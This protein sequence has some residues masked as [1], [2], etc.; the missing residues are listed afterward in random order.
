MQVREMNSGMT[1]RQGEGYLETFPEYGEDC[2]HGPYVGYDFGDGWVMFT[3][4]N[5]PG[6]VSFHYEGEEE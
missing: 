5:K 6:L 1:F 3:Y 2:D 4:T